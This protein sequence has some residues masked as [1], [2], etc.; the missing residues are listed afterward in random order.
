MRDR[1]GAAAALIMLSATP[2]VPAGPRV[3]VPAPPG[4]GAGPA[5]GL[6]LKVAGP[7]PGRPRRPG[8]LARRQWP[9]TVTPA[10]TGASESISGGPRLP[11]QLSA[12]P[13]GGPGRAPSRIRL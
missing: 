8:S 1:D 13:A 9:G 12:G 4:A 7:G 11:V 5:W 3:T 2:T 10:A 6:S